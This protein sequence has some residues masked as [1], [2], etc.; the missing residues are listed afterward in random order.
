MRITYPYYFFN[1]IDS[2]C[3]RNGSMTYKGPTITEGSEFHFGG[4]EVEV[5]HSLSRNEFLSGA[6]F[7]KGL[8][9][10][11]QP[12]SSSA[13]SSGPSRQFK[14]PQVLTKPSVPYNAP[15]RRPIPLHPVSVSSANN[16]PKNDEKD[17]SASYWSANWCVIQV[18]CV[19]LCCLLSLPS[20]RKV[21]TKKHK[22]WEGDC[23]IKQSGKTM[24]LI[25]DQGKV[26][27]QLS[28]CS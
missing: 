11:F 5:D 12:T 1:I 19:I 23:F 26:S 6:C 10:G 8:P 17:T 4:K 27:E 14:A 15:D 21:S 7:G 13:G 22:I 18:A 2:N 20:R 16:I 28:F 9:S 25:S 3:D 24:T